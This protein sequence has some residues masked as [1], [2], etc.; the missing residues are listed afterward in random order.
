[1]PSFIRSKTFGGLLLA[2]VFSVSA[3][4][5]SP[6]AKA[7]SQKRE[8]VQLSSGLFLPP[9]DPERGKTLFASKGCVVCHSINGVGGTDAPVIDASTMASEMNPF[10]FVAKMWN[11]SEGMIA[12]Q[13]NEMGRQITFKNGQEIADIIAFLHDSPLQKTFGRDDIPPD[14]AKLMEEGDEGDSAG[15]N[16]NGMMN[17]SGMMN[18]SNMMG[19]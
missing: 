9:L 17:G 6:P 16:S 12:M 19:Q 15:S 8:G 10:D 18:N 3:M 5:H 1:M 11:H 4:I 14:I 2:A 13:R 7:A